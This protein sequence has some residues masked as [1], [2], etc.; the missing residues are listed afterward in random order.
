[1]TSSSRPLL[2]SKRR[3]YFKAR[4]ILKRIAQNHDG[5]RNKER[6]CWRGPTKNYWTGLDW[7]G[8]IAILRK[9]T[10]NPFDQ[11]GDPISK[12][13]NGFGTNVN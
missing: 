9:T 10:L 11:K 5:V 4:K 8:M 7:T 1:V 13:I 3:P 12:H 2:S 6:S